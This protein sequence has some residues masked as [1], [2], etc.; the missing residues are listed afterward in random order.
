MD[1]RARRGEATGIEIKNGKII[2]VLY[3]NSYVFL[4]VWFVFIGGGGDS[5]GQWRRRW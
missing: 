4:V 2:L 5:V 1:G 3:N